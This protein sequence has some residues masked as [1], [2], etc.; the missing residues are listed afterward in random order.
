MLGK[1]ACI[2][3]LSRDYVNHIDMIEALA[4]GDGA[5]VYA[6]EDAI[7]IRMPNGY[8]YLFWADS[9]EAAGLAL[10][11]VEAMPCCV[12]HGAPALAAV[13]AKYGHDYLSHCYQAAYLHKTPAAVAEGYD[14]RPLDESYTEVVA[15]NYSLYYDPDEMRETLARGD[16]L[17]AFVDGEL[18]G[19]VGIHD[20]GSCGMLEVFPPYRRR[21]IGRAL[22][23]AITNLCLDRGWTPY[24]Q[25]LSHNAASLALQRTTGMTLSAEM[26]HWTLYQDNRDEKQAETAAQD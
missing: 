20:D 3:L 21:G 6:E 16:M 13:Q 19:F 7:L 10:A 9:R 12:S 24:G 23:A 5:L 8:Q 4:R 18:V 11:D 25:I 17:G 26:V 14:I 2:A 15:R 22:E 1:D